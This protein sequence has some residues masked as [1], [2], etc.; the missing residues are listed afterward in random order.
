MTWQEYQ[1]AVGEL[2][3]N[4]DE[5]GTV[6]RAFTIPDKITGQPR[7]IDV[8]VEIEAYEH[9]LRLVVDA[10]FRSEKINVKD[11]EEVLALAEAVNA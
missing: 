8:L 3:E 2:Y 9:T 6:R 10:K 11:V 1:D 7:Q 4:L 5:L